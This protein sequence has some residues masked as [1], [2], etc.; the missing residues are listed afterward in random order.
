MR[1]NNEH[2]CRLDFKVVLAPNFPLQRDAGAKVFERIT[3]SH[4]DGRLG[5]CAH[6]RT[7]VFPARIA[8]NFSTSAALARSQS[9][10]I[11]LRGTF[12][13]ARP[14]ARASR[15]ISWKR[16]VNFA[17]L[18]LS[19]ISGSTFK[20]RARLTAANSTSPSSSSICSDDCALRAAPSSLKIG[21][22]HV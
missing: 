21:R 12:A 17:L 6:G 19:A 1:G 18:R 14:D 22:A 7:A 13:R 8:D 9:D 5:R 16:D 11:S 10:S 4:S 15:S 3:A 20:K 2:G